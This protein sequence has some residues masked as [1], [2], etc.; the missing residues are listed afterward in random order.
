MIA[1]ISNPDFEWRMAIF[2]TKAQECNIQVPDDVCEYVVAHIQRNIRELEGALN[3]LSAFYRFNNKSPTLQEARS[4]LRNIIQNPNKAV[5]PK[6][7]IQLVA[8]CYDMKEKDIV[9]LSRKKETVRPRQIAM[10][11]LR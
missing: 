6:K 3:R 5:S 2:K 8:E 7:I 1:D 11:L 4:L 9:A 10:Y